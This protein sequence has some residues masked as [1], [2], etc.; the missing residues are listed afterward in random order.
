MKYIPELIHFFY[1]VVTAF[2]SFKVVKI[3]LIAFVSIFVLWLVIC[4]LALWWFRFADLHVRRIEKEIET[5][6]NVEKIL[7]MH[8]VE[9]DEAIL[10]VEILLKNGLKMYFS[11]I[12]ENESD[13]LVFAVYMSMENCQVNLIEYDAQKDTISIDR[14][15]Y[16]HLLDIGNSF[17]TAIEKSQELY[18]KALALPLLSE[19][20]MKDRDGL[21]ALLKE[22][23]KDFILVREDIP[24]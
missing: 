24:D 3:V 5:N 19:E 8:M 18:E 22:S 17:W 9:D 13:E 20:E 14:N 4:F 7:F 16:P 21:K 12:Y 6:N 23:G 15:G 10:S 2:F 11:E 1:D